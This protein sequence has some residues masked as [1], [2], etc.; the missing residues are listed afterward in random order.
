MS[1]PVKLKDIARACGYHPSAVSR[2]LLGD[3]K[4]IS[5]K[6]ISAVLSTAA[7]MGYAG[8]NGARIDA[9]L[10]HLLANRQKGED[11]TRLEIAEACGCTYEYIRITEERAI[12]KLRKRLLTSDWSEWLSDGK[13]RLEARP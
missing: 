6:C 1:A 8:G 10:D 9:G 12:E 3:R 4:H 7:A 2:V 5:E 13:G 11:F